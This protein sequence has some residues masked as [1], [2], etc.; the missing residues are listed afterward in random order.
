MFKKRDNATIMPGQDE[1]QRAGFGFVLIFVSVLCTLLGFGSTLAS[2]PPVQKYLMKRFTETP[3]VEESMETS[4]VE[5]SMET[6]TVEELMETS[7]VEESM[8]TS[9]V[10]VQ[11]RTATI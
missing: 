3:T 7:T 6:P 1:Y 5:K 4:T 11:P 10:I 8:R 9:E 2:I